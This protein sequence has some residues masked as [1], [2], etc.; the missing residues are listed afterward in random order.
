MKKVLFA[1]AALLLTT[2]HALAQSPLSVETATI[3][4]N[5]ESEL[6][7]NFQFDTEGL[8]TAYT[9]DFELP[10]GISFATGDNGKYIYTAGDCHA[11]THTF[12][13]SYNTDREAWAVGCLSLESDPLTGASGMLITVAVQADD[14]I[15]SLTPRQMTE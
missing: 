15:S 10:E 3:P 13:L 8:Y 7:V 9:F 12:A 5:G 11:E 1:M 4:Q 14:T 6:V 2:G